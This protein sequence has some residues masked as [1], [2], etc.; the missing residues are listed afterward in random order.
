MTHPRIEMFLRERDRAIVRQDY[1]VIR[2]LTAD[3][4]RLGVPDNATLAHPRGAPARVPQNGEKA[5]E[6]PRNGAKPP[7]CEHGS[8][9][10]RCVECNPE[11]VAH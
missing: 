10:E 4:R 11:L 9:A 1:G 6:K 8:V 5:S 2:S 3:L 7:K